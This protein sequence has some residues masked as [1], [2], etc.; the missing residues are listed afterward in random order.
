[1]SQ[2]FDAG[3]R[4]FL[5]YVM[6]ASAG[7]T[8]LAATL[9]AMGLSA[10]VAAQTQGDY[11]A[12]ICLYMNGGFDG[13]N[14]LIPTDEPRYDIYATGRSNLAIDRTQ[15]IDLGNSYGLHPNASALS[16]LFAQKRM[17]ACAN[18]GSLIAPVSK[19]DYQAG[20][21]LPRGLYAHNIQCDSVVAAQSNAAVRRGWAGKLADLMSSW[22]DN[23]YVPMNISLSGQNFAQKG[24]FVAPY[25]M[26]LDGVV[27]F[28]VANSANRWAVLESQL[29]AVRA[30]SAWAL[31]SEHATQTL[32]AYETSVYLKGIM[33][34]A[35]ALSVSWP[36]TTLARSLKTIADMISVR[37]QLGFRR[38]IFFVRLG[39]F[40]THNDHLKVQGD[41]L[42]NMS[43][44]LAAFQS[45][46]DQLGVTK[47]VTTFAVSEFGRTLTSNGDGTDH[48][49]GNVWYAL[50]GAVKGGKI[51]GQFPDQT[52]GSNDDVGRGRYIPT[53]AADQFNATLARWFGVSDSD[54]DVIFPNLSR[55]ESRD[56]GFMKS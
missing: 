50:G 11:K 37:E 40:D 6:A 17:M 16:S 21:N 43:D 53:T 41:H 25:C 48:A 18:V 5:R 51:Y 20:K 47:K 28:S 14:L 34:T 29:E 38:Q 44:S 10:Q 56:L 36:D 31:G 19:S 9:G 3:R 42:S 24:E 26:G 7:S 15:L 8:R 32:N 46:M 55:F 49:W 2:V 54:L 39:S 1:M 12:M 33:D 27:T 13:W 52:L 45:A 22:N 4:R 30:D 35:P 23:V